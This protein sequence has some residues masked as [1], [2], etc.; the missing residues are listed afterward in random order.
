M[1]FKFQERLE[2]RVKNSKLGEEGVLIY[3]LII[4]TLGISDAF[5]HQA[6]PPAGLNLHLPQT[7]ATNPIVAEILWNY[8]SVQLGAIFP[9]L[10]LM[11]FYRPKKNRKEFTVWLLWMGKMLLIAMFIEQIVVHTMTNILVFQGLVEPIDYLHQRYNLWTS[12]QFNLHFTFEQTLLFNFLSF[13]LFCL[14]VVQERRLRKKW[15]L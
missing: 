4:L 5:L 6:Y 2:K 12:K 3:L 10:L 14:F 7:I 8:N 9:I 15:K 1:T 11:I 13:L